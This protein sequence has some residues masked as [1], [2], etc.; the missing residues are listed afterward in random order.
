MRGCGGVSLGARSPQRAPLGL[1]QPILLLTN[2]E[3]QA[4]LLGRGSWVVIYLFI[5]IFTLNVFFVSLEILRKKNANTDLWRNLICERNRKRRYLGT[6][7][8][9]TMVKP[10]FYL[11]CSEI[12]RSASVFIRVSE[13]L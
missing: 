9:S 13:Y 11:I 8:L 12:S 1:A 10:G 7:P 4:F 3:L 5:F 2:G 6:F